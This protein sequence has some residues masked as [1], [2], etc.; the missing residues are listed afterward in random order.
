LLGLISCTLVIRE[1]NI[2][3][4]SS[5]ET[6]IKSLKEEVAYLREENKSF[7]EKP[8][9]AEKKFDIIRKEL[10]LNGTFESVSGDVLSA[11]S[12]QVSLLNILSGDKCLLKFGAKGEP[13]TYDLSDLT[14]MQL[15][16][17]RQ[18]FYECIEIFC[19]REYD[20]LNGCEEAVAL[21]LIG[22]TD[23]RLQKE[24]KY[25]FKKIS[26]M[27]ELV[28]MY[29]EMLMLVC[30]NIRF[31]SKGSRPVFQ[32][33]KVKDENIQKK[34]DELNK[35]MSD[36]ENRIHAQKRDIVSIA[37]K[38]MGNLQQDNK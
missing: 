32:C 28:S 30:D 9:S 19:N 13:V 27:R 3:D 23:E 14:G 18:G 37:L 7:K 22:N 33:A 8:L 2:K 5:Y 16:N 15:G 4:N 10:K 6:K 36:I 35:R 17:L 31:Y 1:I 20:G 25:I 11:V 34:I 29:R 24:G 12:S 38:E 21:L 26:A